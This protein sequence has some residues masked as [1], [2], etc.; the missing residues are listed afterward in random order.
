MRSSGTFTQS[1]MYYKHKKKL[2]YFVT[3]GFRNFLQTI[4]SDGVGFSENLKWTVGG[5][6]WR[7]LWKLPRNFGAPSYDLCHN[8][9]GPAA[10]QKL[11]L[12]LV[13]VVLGNV[14]DPAKSNQ[15]SLT[16][17]IIFVLQTRQTFPAVIRELGASEPRIERSVTTPTETFSFYLLNLKLGYLLGEFHIFWSEK[18]LRMEGQSGIHAL[19]WSEL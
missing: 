6:R 11:D 5:E 16:Q 10:E 13:S 15:T 19:L 2:R 8:L 18:I 17:K 14:T 7:I 1:R 3:C 9:M 4:P 12:D